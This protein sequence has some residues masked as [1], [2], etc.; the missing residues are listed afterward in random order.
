MGRGSFESAIGTGT[1]A[2]LEAKREP[3]SLAK[4]LVIYSV[5]SSD[6]LA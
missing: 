5:A 2:H 3:D 1:T 4:S 6:W